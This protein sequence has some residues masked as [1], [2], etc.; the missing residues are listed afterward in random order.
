MISDI[1]FIPTGLLEMRQSS[2]SEDSS[3]MV[4]QI[5]LTERRTAIRRFNLIYKIND[6]E[7]KDTADKIN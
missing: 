5:T 6:S 7:S 3:T 2:M 1:L 4:A